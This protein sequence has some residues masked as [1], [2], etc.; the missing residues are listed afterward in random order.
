MGESGSARDA[1]SYQICSR[2]VMDVSDPDIEFDE[3]GVC[4]HCHLYVRLK[5]ERLPAPEAAAGELERIAAQ[6]K[7]AGAGREYDCVIGLSGGVDSSY[8]AYLVRRLELRP[9]AIHL[10]NGWDSVVAVRNI[11]NIV[12]KLGI[13]LYTHVV[14]WEEFRDVQLSFFKASVIDIELL[15][16]NAITALLYREARRHRISYI[17][18]GNN[19]KTEVIM[20]PAWIHR[21]GDSRNIRSIHRRFGSLPIRTLPMISTLQMRLLALLSRVQTVNLLDFV[22]YDKTKAMS[23]LKDELGWTYYGGKHYESLFTRFYQS[24]IL[25]TKFGVDKRRAHFSTL[26]CSEQMTREDA[27]A[28]LEKP[29]YDP[30]TVAQE[31]AYVVKKLGLSEQEFV[32]LMKL[33]VR[34]HL[35]FG[36]EST[37]LHRLS[38]FRRRFRS[39]SGGVG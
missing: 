3:D 37:Y 25:P 12:T 34:S 8:V 9:L 2:C 1:V 5:H 36:S 28:E 19:F 24:Y 17:I 29:P 27:L 22:D 23:V 14:D 35:E 33:P 6:V 16:D 26:I 30:D 31:R 39:S 38:W 4:N 15:T 32:E 21:K 10:D 18:S 7:R 13:D 11:E 20:P